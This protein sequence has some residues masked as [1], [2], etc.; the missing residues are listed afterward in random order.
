M[1]KVVERKVIL[2]YRTSKKYKF[3]CQYLDGDFKHNNKQHTE[4]SRQQK[5]YSQYG[6]KPT[7]YKP[8]LSDTRS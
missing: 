8:I 7:E 2:L 4:R 6:E 5:D 1:W 3:T